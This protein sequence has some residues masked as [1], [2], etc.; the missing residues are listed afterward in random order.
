MG[1]SIFLS[2]F[3]PHKAK[4]GLKHTILYSCTT[5]YLS[6]CSPKMGTSHPFT[7]DFKKFTSLCPPLKSLTPYS[8]HPYCELAMVV[9]HMAARIGSRANKLFASSFQENEKN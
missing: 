6:P 3:P 1:L 8:P 7:W 5:F 9:S 2:V 4:K